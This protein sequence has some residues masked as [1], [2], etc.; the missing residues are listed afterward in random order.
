V[1]LPSTRDQ[2][3]DPDLY[4]HYGESA[5]RAGHFKEAKEILQKVYK[6]NTDHP[7]APMALALIS[8]IL[9]KE[10]DVTTAQAMTDKIY[11][12]ESVSPTAKIGKIIAA[13]GRL[14][15]I[16]CPS[17]CKSETV[18][19][20][21]KHIETEAKSLF[22]DRPLTT[23]GQ[24]AVLDGLVE[25]RR[26]ISY[27]TA[28]TL[29]EQMIPNLPSLS[30]YLPSVQSYLNQTVLEH[31]EHIEEPQEVISLFH[32]FRRAFTASK[33]SGEVGFKIAKSNIELVLLAYA[34]EYFKPIASNT[35]KPISED[36][37]YYL[38]ALLAQMGQFPDAQNLLETFLSRYPKRTDVLLV[39]GDV[40]NAQGKINLA[41][42]TYQKWLG[43]HP[44]HDD[45]KT[46]YRK[47]ADAYR[48]KKE[49]DNEIKTYIQWI[50]EEKEESER[51]NIA[52]AD[53]YYQKQNYSNAIEYYQRALRVEKDKKEVDWVK[54]R[55]GASYQAIGNKEDAA[56]FFQDVSKEAKTLIIKKTARDKNATIKQEKKLLE[57]V[58]KNEKT[59]VA[60]NNSKKNVKNQ[61]Q[62]HEKTEKERS[63]H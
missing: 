41:I 63:G 6:K 13:T 53:A 16:D 7:V 49:I 10:G 43:G 62:D 9:R 12:M 4:F 46:V 58:K 25:I 21:I 40:Y 1:L 30:P 57:D 42:D 14:A 22:L 17:P 47:L 54:L 20:S 61:K 15:S 5:Y 28:E 37:F 39:L 55:L 8:N 36:A 38:G 60:E 29:Y 45:R 50:A 11:L 31:F 27:E 3:K 48:V 32:R 51:P 34:I 19:Q 2:V 24:I 23:S 56:K 35:G 59:I 52:L 33:M 18:K 26:H 44:K